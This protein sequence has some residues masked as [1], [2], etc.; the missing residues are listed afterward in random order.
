MKREAHK[1]NYLLQRLAVLLENDERMY[2]MLLKKEN[3]LRK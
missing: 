2:S 3:E 1:C